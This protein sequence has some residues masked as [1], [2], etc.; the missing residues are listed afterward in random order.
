MLPPHPDRMILTHKS[1]RSTQGVSG[2]ALGHRSEP[3]LPFP[4]PPRWKR[5][6]PD[7]K[8]SRRGRG[9]KRE[10]TCT[11]GGALRRLPWATVLRPSG[12]ENP[13][14]MGVSVP[15]VSSGKDMGHDQPDRRGGCEMVGACGCEKF[16]LGKGGSA[17]GAGVV[18]R[19]RKAKGRW[20]RHSKYDALR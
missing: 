15:P 7:L 5:V 3:P 8:T 17:V 14:S 2:S 18:S 9:G 11:Q 19:D 20:W 1:G 4:S 16:P 13:L 12:A 6:S 10:V